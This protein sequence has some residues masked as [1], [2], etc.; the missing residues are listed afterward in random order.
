VAAPLGPAAESPLDASVGSPP[1]SSVGG[2]VF[3]LP[4]PDWDKLSSRALE[5]RPLTWWVV[6]VSV[7]LCV[8]LMVVF[9]SLRFSTEVRSY[10]GFYAGIAVVAV[11][12]SL[13]FWATEQR[14]IRLPALPALRDYLSDVMK[15]GTE[16]AHHG[17]DAGFHL[18]A[19]IILLFMIVTLDGYRVVYLLFGKSDFTHSRLSTILI[20]SVCSLFCIYLDDLRALALDAKLKALASEIPLTAKTLAS[21]VVFAVFAWLLT[22]PIG[23]QLSVQPSPLLHYNGDFIS[24]LVVCKLAITVAV[25]LGLAMIALYVPRVRS[26]AWWA[27]AAWVVVEATTYGQFKIAGPHTWTYPVPFRGLNYLNVPTDVLRPPSQT[28]LDSFAAAFETDKYRSIL[29]GGSVEFIGSKG[30]F[31]SCFWE[32]NSI[33]GYGT[34]VPNRLASLPW[35]KGVQTLRTIE[36]QPQMH[37]DPSIL[38]FLNVKY[39]L[40]NTPG[41]YFNVPGGSD[42]SAG[43]ADE[44]QT[45]IEGREIQFVKNP[46]TPL[47]RE[48]LARTVVGTS[49]IPEFRIESGHDAAAPGEDA[50]IYGDRL[51][52]L[53]ERSFAEGGA[54]S[55]TFDASGPI[56]AKYEGD[57]II[58]NVAPSNRERFVVLNMRY[59]P[60]WRVKADRF[61]IRP[62]PTNI[63]MMG[64]IVPQ[65]Q[66]EVTLRFQPF[67][68]RLPARLLMWFAFFAF[69][70]VMA[71]IAGDKGPWRYARD[72]FS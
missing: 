47:P 33:G 66:S 34:G 15:V 1:R 32:A 72:R 6:A 53:R 64:F 57:N 24:K 46:V 25:I 20:L 45:S 19:V 14:R 41:L 35:A 56:D 22:G 49:S 54:E 27:I 55:G 5:A 2:P 21:A 9:P 23:D 37:V 65:G 61:D 16:P 40:R 30:A 62:Y 59:H 68:T 44:L 31:V 28:E 12:L 3:A 42:P 4:N 7:A 39:V 13:S 10:N 70:L 26:M 17:R 36:I 50:T 60:D 8:L 43:P 38:A 51:D 58:V 48:F 71:C 11:V 63:T 29:D 67:S 52:D 69:L 18:F